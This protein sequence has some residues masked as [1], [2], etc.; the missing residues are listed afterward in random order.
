MLH[1]RI[2]A[3]YVTNGTH[4]VNRTLKYEPVPIDSQKMEINLQQTNYS[5]H[6]I[7]IYF[8][9]LVRFE[10]RLFGFPMTLPIPSYDIGK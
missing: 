10:I 3:Q 6:V 7:H 5:T 1:S 2:E 8:P 4:S 9:Y